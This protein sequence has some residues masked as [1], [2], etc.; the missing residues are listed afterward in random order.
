MNA[1]DPLRSLDD[2]RA[3]RRYAPDKW[4][5]KQTLGHVTDAER[6]FAYRMLRIARGDE[7]PL[8]GFEQ[9]DY[10]T[11]ANFDALPLAGLVDAFRATRAATIA[12]TGEISG[13]AWLRTGTASGFRVSARALLYIITGHL[14][15]HLGILRE[16]YDVP[17]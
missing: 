6:V 13:D 8:A 12:L 11:A 16:R 7:T 4:S 17:V 1:F 14:A 2:S 3:L 15:H 9:N 10:V 5:V